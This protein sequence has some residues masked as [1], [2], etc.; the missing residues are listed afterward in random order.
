MQ[1]IGKNER[2]LALFVVRALSGAFVNAFFSFSG[3][4]SIAVLKSKKMN[5]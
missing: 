2:E 5:M 1:K 3:F 4:S